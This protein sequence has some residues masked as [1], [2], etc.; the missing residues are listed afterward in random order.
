MEK[1]E[2]VTLELEDLTNEELKNVI[3]QCVNQLIKNAEN[4]V[5]SGLIMEDGING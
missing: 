3:T 1:N 2:S 5:I 4:R